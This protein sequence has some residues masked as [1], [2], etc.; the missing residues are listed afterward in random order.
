MHREQTGCN[1][2]RSLGP[3]EGCRAGRAPHRTNSRLPTLARC[4]AVAFLVLAGVLSVAE[5]AQAYVG[6][7][8][9]L[10]TIG[11]ALGMLMTGASA[12]FYLSMLWLRRMWRR[13]VS[14]FQPTRAAPA[15]AKP[16]HSDP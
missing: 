13:V 7:G 2:A 8:M 4:L 9:E 5:P 3:G 14:L 15:E 11:A 1:P 10:G 16:V 6:P 12:V